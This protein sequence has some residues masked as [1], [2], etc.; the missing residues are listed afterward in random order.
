MEL[1]IERPD[2]RSDLA[3]VD[4]AGELDAASYLDLIEAGRRLV[5]EGARN[6]V[7]DL[8][9][10]T[11]LGSSGLVALHSLALLAAGREPPDPEA[12]WSA[13]HGLGQAI[14]SAEGGKVTLVGPQ[15]QVDRTLER[16]GMKRLFEIHPDRAAAIAS[17]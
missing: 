9:N 1:T 3:V 17:F 13:F 5:A 11:Y 8:T 2:G 7:V 6:L 12:G 15:P 16:T 14:E 4:V 10:L